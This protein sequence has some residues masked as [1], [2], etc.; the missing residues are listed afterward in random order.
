MSGA[1]L[2]RTRTQPGCSPDALEL[3]CGC[4]GWIPSGGRGALHDTR[5]A[6]APRCCPRPHSFEL[7]L[8][9]ETGYRRLTDKIV[10][11]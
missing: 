4:A 2:T 7:N 8:P 10:Q 1:V 6:C 11:E 3:K 9:S 5:G